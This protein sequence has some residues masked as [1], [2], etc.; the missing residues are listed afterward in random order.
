MPTA[1]CR[2]FNANAVGLGEIWHPLPSLL[3]IRC[4]ALP[5]NFPFSI[6]RT[7]CEHRQAYVGVFAAVAAIGTIRLGNPVWFNP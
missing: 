7:A 1:N 4:M 6:L 2:L 5:R 3:G